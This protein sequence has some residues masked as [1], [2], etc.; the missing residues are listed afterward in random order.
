[1]KF[2]FEGLDGGV[3]EWHKEPVD[4][5][6]Y[7]QITAVTAERECA[8]AAARVTREERGETRAEA[9]IQHAQADTEAAVIAAGIAVSEA[10][11]ALR[12]LLAAHA[13]V[14]EGLPEITPDP[15]FD[16]DADA[17][18]LRQRGE[19]WTLHAIA[20]R[21]LLIIAAALRIADAAALP[22]L[23]PAHQRQAR[24]TNILARAMRADLAALIHA[25]LRV[26][27]L[28]AIARLARAGRVAALAS[29]AHARTCC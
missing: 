15:E 10:D 18:W 28:A 6:D 9:Q 25:R 17:T 14:L 7:H 2:F 12:D 5:A 27:H 3:K 16:A 29:A 19:A 4:T 21:R 8:R 26:V 23:L 1:M 11:P 22:D 20:R 13:H 24:L